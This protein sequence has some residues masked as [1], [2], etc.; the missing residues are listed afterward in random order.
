M[1]A[2]FF[3]RCLG[4]PELRG[5]GGEAVRFRVRKHLALLSFLAAE[6]REPH[7]RDRLVDLLWPDARPAEG[8]HSLATALSVLR[9]RF[10]PRT[11]ETTRDTIRLLAP[12]LEVD[13]DRLA[14]GDVLGDDQRPPLEVAGFLEG[15][16]ITRAPEFMFWRD[17]MRARWLP[18]IRDALVVLLDRCRR[19]GDF[20]AIEP[21]ADR[22][23]A[24]D[25]LAEDAVR[26][27]MEARAFAGD[28]VSALRIFRTWRDQLAEELDAAPSPLVEGMALRLRQRGYTPA[29]SVQLP[30]VATEQWRDHAFVGRTHQYRV[31]YERW[32]STRDGAG[33]HGLVLGDSGLGKTTLLER[34]TMATGLEGAVS[35]RVQCYEMEQQIP[36]AA[37]GGLVRVLLERPGAGGTSPEWLAELARM[38]PTVALRYRN[39][40]PP[41]D[42]AGE[43][44]RLRFTE[45]VHELITAVAEEHPLVLVVDDVHLADDASIAVLHLLM[46]RTQE[47][48]VTLLLAARESELQGAPSARRLLEVM[49]PLALVPVRLEPLTPEEMGVVI[50]ALAAG[51]GRELPAAARVALLQAAA[52]VPMLAELLFDDWRQ[53][54][55]QCLAL[56]VGAM[57]EDPARAPDHTTAYEQLFARVLRDLS[58]TARSALH[59]AAILG[60]RLNDLSMYDIVDLSLADTLRGMAELTS[61][62]ILRDGGKGVE[63]RN[64]LLRRYTYLEVPSPVRRA[65]HGRIADRLLAAEGRG[66]PV[67]GLMLAWHCYR[68]GRAAEAE[69]Y[70][71][72][73]AQETLA[74]GAPVEAELALGSA[75]PSLSA[76]H[77]V[78]AQLALVQALQEQGRWEESLQSLPSGSSDHL[79][80]MER[81]LQ[82]AGRARLCAESRLAE[83]LVGHVLDSLVES[84]DDTERVPLLSA[85]YSLAFSVQRQNTLTEILA[86]TSD[87]SSGQRLFELRV[88]AARLLAIVAYRKRVLSQFP[89]LQEILT[90][91][92][93]EAQS[94]GVESSAIAAL[95]NTLGALAVGKGE[96]HT[97]IVCMKE[98]NRLYGKLGDHLS[99]CVTCQNLAMSYGRL[100]QYKLALDW[101]TRGV[102]LGQAHRGAWQ[103]ELASL[104]RAWALAMLGLTR[105]ATQQVQ[106]LRHTWQNHEIS[107]VRQRQGLFTADLCLLTG[108]RSEADALASEVAE[109]IGVR[110]LSSGEVGRSARWTYR[111]RASLGVRETLSRLEDVA[112]NGGELELL[113]QA[114]V[115]GSLALCREE[116]GFNSADQREQLSLALARLP[117]PVTIQ[118]GRLEA[119]R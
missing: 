49:E 16:E 94:R 43:S 91:L 108:A 1:P 107:W 38:I 53:H 50:D 79:S 55:E 67:P 77:R 104:W 119:L 75:L 28:R 71:L 31:L 78:P 4:S 99:A 105:E 74:K 21:H 58:P 60:D 26:A 63:F 15:F 37:V 7:R 96:Y 106:G 112:Y 10:G 5:P 24:L 25:P 64:E 65:V 3:F 27:K 68:A 52:G 93:S 46:R 82:L 97:A 61:T 83:D 11:F 40:P 2:R 88:A 20:A 17:G 36:Y 98:S 41:R 118:L 33:R 100:G 73:G 113:D 51:A 89:D 117:E 116:L 19:T 39:L 22:L 59:L 23:L 57:T 29:G 9:A 69:P 109:D 44:A 102:A 80:G 48:R 34:L 32:E 42:T 86:I 70:L 62:R 111:L 18:P 56:A 110:P 54:G 6:P 30:P 35:A 72:R 81:A 47:Q 84:T 87:Y 92:S 66:E 103:L 12:D 115:F 45:A 90:T 13:L 8:R 101:S 14:R 114:E 85:A 76:R 95:S